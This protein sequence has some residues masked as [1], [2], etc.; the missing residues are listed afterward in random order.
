MSEVDKKIKK[1]VEL[2]SDCGKDITEISINIVNRIK[3]IELLHKYNLVD[4]I[5]NLDCFHVSH[6][7]LIS[8]IRSNETEKIIQAID[9][10]V[11][12][13][14]Y[15]SQYDNK[16]N[17]TINN[18][19]QLLKKIKEDF[20][21]KIGGNFAEHFLIVNNIIESLHGTNE[22]YIKN[23]GITDITDFFSLVKY[24]KIDELCRVNSIRFCCTTLMNFISYISNISDQTSKVNLIDNKLIVSMQSSDM[25]I[26]EE[27]NTE[28]Y[29]SVVLSR[30]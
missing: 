30:V 8:T 27:I 11:T 24:T 26:N 6:T 21:T 29:C 16:L 22:E 15:F 12:A 13:L 19:K 4:L 5:K 10:A 17:P 28:D 7:L 3:S 9:S 14:D 20:N 18:I 2:L 25:T 1:A 23:S